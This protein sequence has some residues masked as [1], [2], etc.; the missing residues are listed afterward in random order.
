MIR[1]RSRWLLML[2][3]VA[4]AAAAMIALQSVQRPQPSWETFSRVEEGMTREQVYATVGGPPGDYSTTWVT[5]REGLAPAEVWV[6]GDYF[7]EV[8][9]DREGRADRVKLYDFSPPGSSFLQRAR[10]WLG[11]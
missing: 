6:R 11:L 1:R 5:D 4:L 2:G 10:D 9:F 7:L 8:T 3:A